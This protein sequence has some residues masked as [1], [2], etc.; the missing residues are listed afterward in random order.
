[1]D[2]EKKSKK[3]IDIHTHGAFGID[4]NSANYDEINFALEKYYS[5]SICAICPTLVGDL[6]ENIFRQL[7]LFKKIRQE[8]LKNPKKQALILG[9]HLEGTFL[10]PQKAGIQNPKNFKKLTKENFKNLVK[11][12]Q[13][14]IKIVTLAPE[15]D[16]GLIDYLN[17]QNII[18]QAG[19]TTGQTIQNCKGVT[20]IFN[21]MS[22]IHHRKKSIALEALLDDNIYVEVIADLV[23]LSKDILNLILKCKPKNRILFV[24]DCLPCAKTNKEIIFCDKKIYPN[25]KDENGTLAGSYK[26]LSEICENLVQNNIIF[27]DIDTFSFKN[28]INYLKLQKHEIDILNG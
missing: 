9:V 2:F 21:A 12:C 8:Q 28:Q 13:D 5:N 14:I 26:L 19:H 15:E 4:F 20:H 25:G 10:S 3:Y 22:G 17:S 7:S 27:E 11:D 1:M 16:E 24:S 23:H 6:D 18:T